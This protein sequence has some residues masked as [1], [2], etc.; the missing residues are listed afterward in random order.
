MLPLLDHL[1]QSTLFACVAGLLTLA[2]KRNR[3]RVRHWVWIAASVKFLIPVSLLIALG[4]HIEWHKAPA[5][6]NISVVMDEVSQPFT[7]SPVGLPLPVIVPVAASPLPWVLTGIWACGFIGISWS[8]LVRWRRIRDAVRAGVPVEL[9]LGVPLPAVTARVTEPGIFGVLRPVLILPEGIFE[10]LTAGQ[11][12]AVVEH[13]LCHVRHRD[14]LIAAIHM[15]VE[16]IFWFHPMVWWIGKRMVEE[17]ERGCDEEVV[18]RSGEARIYAEAILNVCKLYV[19]SPLECV[20]GVTGADL[21]KRIEGIMARRIAVRLS[22]A[23]KV[24]LAGVGLG[25]VAIPVFVGLMHAQPAMESLLKFE[26]ASVKPTGEDMIDGATKVQRAGGRG[27]VQEA[28]RRINFENINLFGLIVQAY[29]IRGCRPFG[30]GN[31]PLLDGGPDWMRKDGF[32][33]MAKIP[34]DAPDQTLMQLYNGHAPELQ[35]M[36][37]ALLADRFALKIHRITKELPVYALTVGKKGPKLKTSD[38][39]KTRPPLFRPSVG[40][41]GI[42]MIKLVVENGSMQEVVDLYA[43]FLDR[44]AVDRTG[45]KDRYEFTMDYEA[46]AD[47]P[48]AFTEL[49]GPSLFKAFEEQLGL[50]WVATKGTVE[51][52]V[53]DHAEKPSAN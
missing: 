38:G 9:D 27:T 46:N 3:A 32:A 44:P 50:K 20:S 2:L 31:C 43:K 41:D 12:E 37:Q 22:F 29:G 21:K 28:H 52:L 26:V 24:V 34:D 13:E 36:L 7:A 49:V 33:V 17:R 19:E 15:V 42:A 40:P 5:R 4:G 6:S 16:T 10:R 8:W 51:V 30:G 25:V 39:S 45:L 35:L 11:F 53:I 1:W 48:G 23:K 47:T 14:N 18:R